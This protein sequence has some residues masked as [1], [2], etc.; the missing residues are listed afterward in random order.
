MWK[1]GADVTA[2][3]LGDISLAG[4]YTDKALFWVWLICTA[5]AVGVD[6]ARSW[7]KWYAAFLGLL[8]GLTWLPMMMP[9]V[10]LIG[11]ATSFNPGCDVDGRYRVQEVR[12]FPVSKPVVQVIESSGLLEKVVARYEFDYFRMSQLKAVKNLPRKGDSQLS[13]EFEFEWEG[14]TVKLVR[15]LNSQRSL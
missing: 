1:L 5:I 7:A 15:P 4:A 3:W 10:A 12:I 14:E 8:I 13:F 6:F 2:Y 11:F 9:F